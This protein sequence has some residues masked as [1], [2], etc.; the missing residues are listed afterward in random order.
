MSTSGQTFLTVLDRTPKPLLWFMVVLLTIALG[1]ADY[2]TGFEISFAFFYLLPVSIAAWALGRAAAVLVSV[3]CAAI[4][5]IANWLAG[6]GFSSPLIPYWNTITRAGFFIIVSLLLAGMRR[7]LEHER[8]LARTDYLT[9]VLNSRAFYATVEAE[10]MRARRFQRPFTVLYI[11]LDDFKAVN[12]RQGHT[13]GDQVLR[14]AAQAI[15]RHTRDI[16]SVARLGGDEFGVLLPETDDSAVQVLVPRLRQAL[17]KEMEESG[18]PVTF[19][20]GALTCLQPPNGSQELI[21]RADELMYRA[22]NAG[23][24]AIS[25]SVYG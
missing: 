5:L 4:W 24:D 15:L 16:D 25:Y 1:Q 9:G 3:A 20:I 23:K 14:V 19:S 8:S 10:I 22:K 6:A 12:D 7:A 11:D 2:K 17:L 21:R 13:A 18:W